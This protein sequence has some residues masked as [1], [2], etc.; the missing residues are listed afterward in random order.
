MAS[1]KDEYEE[2]ERRPGEAHATVPVPPSEKLRRPADPKELLMRNQVSKVSEM[3]TEE[4]PRAGVPLQRNKAETESG[5]SVVRR[6]D[7]I[8]GAGYEGPTNA[9]L[10][11]EIKRNRQIMYGII[12]LLLLLVIA[13]FGLGLYINHLF[14]TYEQEIKEAFE[15]MDKLDRVIESLQKAYN[16]YSGKIDDL[17]QTAKD[18]KNIVDAFKGA[19]GSIPFFR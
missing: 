11:I 6:E 8:P 5:K 10:M 14:A 17:F 16:D 1:H 15:T 4:P 9:E 3:K 2:L 18:L 13:I 19:I 7:F 12:I